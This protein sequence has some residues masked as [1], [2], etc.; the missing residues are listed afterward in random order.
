MYHSCT[1]N[2]YIKIY[3]FLKIKIKFILNKK[4]N[5]N[6]IKNRKKYF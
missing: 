3:L 5:C 2:I 1:K 6:K 4:K